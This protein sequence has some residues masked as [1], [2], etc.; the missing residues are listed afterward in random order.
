[1]SNKNYLVILDE[2][3]ELLQH[4]LYLRYGSRMGKEKKKV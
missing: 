1:M 4:L 2:F 3:P